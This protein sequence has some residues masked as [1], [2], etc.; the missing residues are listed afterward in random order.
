MKHQLQI[1][2]KYCLHTSNYSFTFF[3]RKSFVF[4]LA[5]KL[6]SK[7][8]S[9]SVFKMVNL[10]C[11]KSKWQAQTSRYKK[12]QTEIGISRQILRRLFVLAINT[13][14]CCIVAKLDFITFI[15]LSLKFCLNCLTHEEKLARK[16]ESS[17]CEHMLPFGWT[18][19]L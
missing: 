7:C 8:N 11:N 12:S 13:E 9:Q 19:S 14:F 18:K 2:F 15:Y 3:K 6:V 1:K 5:L 17:E 10:T 16:N 4:R